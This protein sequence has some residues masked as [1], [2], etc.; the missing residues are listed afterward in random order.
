MEIPND[1]VLIRT[2]AGG[3]P[4]PWAESFINRNPSGVW[5]TP[6]PEVQKSLVDTMAC[7][8]YSAVHCIESQIK[9]LTGQD[10]NFS[11]RFLAKMSGTTQNGNYLQT[12][13][14]TIQQYGLVPDSLW[15]EPDVFDWNTFYM[16]IPQAVIDQ[17]KKF[18]EQWSVDG[19]WVLAS[20]VGD[21]LKQAPL[22]DVI[23]AENPTHAVEEFQVN[24]YF[25]TYQ[26]FVKPLPSV[27]NYLQITINQKENMT[28][29][30]LLKHGTEYGIYD[31][32]TSQDGLITLMRNRGI[33]PPLNPD[34]TLDFSRVDQMVQGQF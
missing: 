17:G 2:E 3:S 23:S 27:H 24:T 15:P 13:L 9:F 28:N 11:E 10:V 18:L 12:V 8:S 32:A 14:E 19:K 6:G 33:E 34:G 4:L 5:P 21:A 26:P 1:G 22:Q 30:L 31:P 25:D 7:V 16:A 20:Q 29:A